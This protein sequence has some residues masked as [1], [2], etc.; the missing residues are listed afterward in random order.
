MPPTSTRCRVST[1]PGRS[2]RRRSSRSIGSGCR[3]DSP[4]PRHSI[5]LREKPDIAGGAAGGAAHARLRCRQT[6]LGSIVRPH[7]RRVRGHLRIPRRGHALHRGWPRRA[8]RDPRRRQI[9]L[10]KDGSRRVPEPERRVD[11]IHAQLAGSR[12]GLPGAWRHV[13]S[14]FDGRPCRCAPPARGEAAWVPSLSLPA[15]GA[16]RGR[17]HRRQ[18]GGRNAV[19]GG[20][21]AVSAGRDRRHLSRRSI[22]SGLP[23]RRAASRRVLLRVRRYP[24]A[25]DALVHEECRLARRRRGGGSR[26]L[27]CGRARRAAARLRQL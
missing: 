8:C 1:S 11:P 21:R 13:Q 22:D 12:R 2:I 15:A 27:A 17:N 20:G 4:N 5:G 26:V 23:A 24:S 14:T 6:G 18:G 19:G 25:P 7:A 9:F 16:A 3:A 10:A